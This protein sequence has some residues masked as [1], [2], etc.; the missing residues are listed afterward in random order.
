[1]AENYRELSHFKNFI[2]FSVNFV[3][4]GLLLLLALAH[5]VL[6]PLTFPDFTKE[7]ESAEEMWEGWDG[8]S[9][10]PTEDSRRCH[11]PLRFKSAGVNALYF[12]S[13]AQSPMAL[14]SRLSPF[15]LIS[16]VSSLNPS[17]NVCTCSSTY[18]HSPPRCA[19]SITLGT[20]NQLT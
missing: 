1:M 4:G 8:P 7:V 14:D 3:L 18:M 2:F 17:R 15:S 11:W 6:T 19:E 13:S 12:Q 9:V 20:T 16:Q 10:S 5:D